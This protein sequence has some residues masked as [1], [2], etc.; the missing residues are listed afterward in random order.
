MS[1]FVVGKEH[2]DLLI[3]A[4]IVL[5]RPY[6]PLRWN[7]SADENEWKPN[8]LDHENAADIGRM[9]WLENYA[10][11]DRLY[12]DDELPGPVGLT[13]DKV[14][15]YVFRA[16]NGSLD[17]VVVLKAIDCYEYQSC[18]HPG[19]KT[20]QARRFCDSLRRACI[21]KLKGYD[22]APWEFSDRNH[23]LMQAVVRVPPA[24]GRSKKS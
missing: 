12:G 6:G 7:T 19:W 21:S 8:Q 14:S 10:S 5:T 17:P 24:E 2:I 1:A 9:L 11:V 16:V 18:E 15:K 13:F 3:T 4:G 20:S 23:F 22:E